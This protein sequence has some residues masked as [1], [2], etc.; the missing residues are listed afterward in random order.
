NPTTLSFEEITFKRPPGCKS[1]YFD[2]FAEIREGKMTIMMADG[3]KNQ[4]LWTTN[5]PEK[6]LKKNGNFGDR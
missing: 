3:K 1:S 6:Y 4:Y 2:R 5:L